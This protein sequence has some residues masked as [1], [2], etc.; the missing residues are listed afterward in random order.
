MEF[1]PQVVR[2]IERHQRRRMFHKFVAFVPLIVILLVSSGFLIYNLSARSQFQQSYSGIDMPYSMSGQMIMVVF[3]RF[4]PYFLIIAVAFYKLIMPSVRQFNS[5]TE[6]ADDYNRL[7]YQ[8]FN[9]ALQATSIG[10]G[11]PAPDLIV[12]KIPTPNSIA[13]K[14]GQ[15]RAVGVTRELL[16]G[17]FSS[18]EAEAIMAHEVSHIVMGDELTTPN[19]FTGVGGVVLILFAI[20]L[21]FFYTVGSIGSVGIFMI[22]IFLLPIIA[23]VGIPLSMYLMMRP[24]SISSINPYYFHYDILADSIAAKLTS[25]PRAL[26]SAIRKVMDSIENSNK[27]PT[28]TIAF[29][30][31]FIGPLKEWELDIETRVPSITEALGRGRH[32]AYRGY[33]GTPTFTWG[34]GKKD[35]RGAGLPSYQ[36]Y[37]SQ[38]QQ[39]EMGNDQYQQLLAASLKGKMVEY[40]EWETKLQQ[41]R[42]ENLELIKRNEWEAFDVRGGIPV[43]PPAKWYS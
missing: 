25:N 12:L 27:M 22:S 30:Q 37:M 8:K 32:P 33:T 13:L 15:S 19:V 1:E 4:L 10:A 38:R 41:A 20:A 23:I 9:N 21:P 36:E 43:A 17:D 40:T 6:L 26:E 5:L 28:Q 39:S 7:G 35:G 24:Y 29:T 11:I 31:L 18:S 14:K 42:L 2:S 34:F 3:I 16:D